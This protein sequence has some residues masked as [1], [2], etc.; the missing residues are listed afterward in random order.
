MD[1]GGLN[2]QRLVSKGVPERLAGELISRSEGGTGTGG[3]NSEAKINAQENFTPEAKLL[4]LRKTNSPTFYDAALGHIEQY[5][6]NTGTK[7]ITDAVNA[8]RPVVTTTAQGRCTITDKAHNYTQ[9]G[10]TTVHTM[11]QKVCEQGGNTAL[12]VSFNPPFLIANYIINNDSAFCEMRCRPGAISCASIQDQSLAVLTF[13]D[14]KAG[15]VCG[16]V[17]AAE[18]ASWEIAQ[19]VQQAA[20]SVSDNIAATVARINAETRNDLESE[21]GRAFILPVLNAYR[22]RGGCEKYFEYAGGKIVARSIEGKVGVILVEIFAVAKYN[23]RE[24][25]IGSAV[26]NTCGHPSRPLGPGGVMRMEAK[27]QFRQYDTGW[28]LEGLI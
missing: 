24:T 17:Q 23:T 20:I 5:Y 15:T 7:L 28:R 9:N 6:R 21:E 18:L 1:G 2:V 25:E 12:N 10:Y 8:R 11:Q 13:P 19:R 4:E 26:A 27:G 16:A 3:L 22:A 14:D